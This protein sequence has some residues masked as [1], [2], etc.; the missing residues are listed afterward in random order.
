M[1]Y[2]VDNRRVVDGMN[3]LVRGVIYRYPLDEVRYL[4]DILKNLLVTCL[5]AV[6]RL[7]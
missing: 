2:V 3:E 1:R 7:I 6:I 4:A 5:R